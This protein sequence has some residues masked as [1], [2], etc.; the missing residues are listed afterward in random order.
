M[1]IIFGEHLYRGHRLFPS[2][3]SLFLAQQL[4]TKH[5]NTTTPHLFGTPSGAC[6]T[7]RPRTRQLWT[8]DDSLDINGAT[9]AFS[10]NYIP[11][12]G[13]TAT[14]CC[15]PSVYQNLTMTESVVTGK[16]GQGAAKPRVLDFSFLDI[17]NLEGIEGLD[18][19][20]LPLGTF[21]SWLASS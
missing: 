8:L 20:N 12:I 17:T 18:L 13:S 4:N 14:Y 10:S 21:Q 11:L 7:S 9:L 15:Q 2:L 6:S 19:V 5:N 3:C 1:D 16:F